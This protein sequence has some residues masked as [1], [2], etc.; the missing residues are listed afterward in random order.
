M[1]IDSSDAVKLTEREASITANKVAKKALSV[2]IKKQLF[3]H[4]WHP[5]TISESPS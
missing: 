2:T 3:I 1:Q 4:A 5:G